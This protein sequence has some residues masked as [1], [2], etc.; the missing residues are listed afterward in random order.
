MEM[1]TILVNVYSY[2][3]QKTAVANTTEIVTRD[4]QYVILYPYK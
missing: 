1:N 3:Y 2:T 4:N